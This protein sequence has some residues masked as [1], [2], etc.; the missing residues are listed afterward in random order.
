LIVLPSGAATPS[1]RARGRSR[2]RL[3]RWLL[4]YLFVAPAVITL[5][6]LVAYPI[7]RVIEISFYKNYLTTPIPE[8]VGLENYAETV[9]QGIFLQAVRNSVIFTAGSVLLHLSC[10][11][12]LALLLNRKFNTKVRAVFRG[13]FI[14]PW[15][16]VNV[17]VAVIWALILHPAGAVNSTLRSA[18][19]MTSPPVD[20]FSDFTLAMPSLI[21][22]NAWVGYAFPMLMLLAGLQSISG[23]LYEAAAVDGAGSWQR[24]RHITIPG[25]GPTIVTVALLDSIW[26]FRLWDLPYLLT[27]GGPVNRTVV[28]PLLTYQ[29]G[30]EGFRFGQA[31]ATAV[32][33]LLITLIFSIFYLTLRTRLLEQS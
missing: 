24:F 33:I 1:P 12:G 9:Q 32:V 27:G 25:L 11:L 6:I 10:G 19:L 29:L 28:L 30:F 14:L 20:W 17:I 3:S 21:I 16:F 22:A 8:F 2:G 4:P 18:G 15:L 31:A 13:V 7:A 5:L 23:D 26:T